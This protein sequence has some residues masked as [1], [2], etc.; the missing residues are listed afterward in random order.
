MLPKQ[1]IQ[2]L[3]VDE[4]EQLIPTHTYIAFMIMG[5]GIEF[6]GKCLDSQV[7]DWNEGKS[8]DRFEFAIKSLFAFSRYKQLIGRD[9]RFDLYSSLRC[10]L[11]HCGAPKRQITLSRKMRWSI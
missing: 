7:D 2:T 5:I 11:A 10:G 8:R 6:L 9:T 4:V 3:F 1:F